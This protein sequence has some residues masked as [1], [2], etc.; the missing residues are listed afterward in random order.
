MF[1][2]EFTERA[3]L[4]IEKH[5]KT[6]NKVAGFK[7]LDT[8]HES[9]TSF[10]NITD[11]RIDSMDSGLPNDVLDIFRNEFSNTKQTNC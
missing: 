6:G 8:S 4:D 1:E 7:N 11:Q 5:K 10:W 3:K 9:E 2:I